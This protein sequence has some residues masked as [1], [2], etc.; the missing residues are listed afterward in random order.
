MN[1][2]SELSK[3]ITILSL[4]FCLFIA[5]IHG[6]TDTLD[7]AG[8][9]PK[10]KLLSLFDSDELIDV[11]LHFDIPAFLRTQPDDKPLEAEMTFY[12][13]GNDSLN[14]KITVKPRGFFRRKNCGFP[15]IML[16]FK[17]AVYANPD[18]FK[19]KKVKLVTHCNNGKFSDD[20]VA[21]EYLLYRMYNV[22]T[23]TS[24]RVRLLRINY[25]DTRGKKKEA[26]Q[27]GFL[28]EPVE[29]LAERTNCIVLTSN[30]L[31][32]KS[33]IPHTMNTVAIFNYMVANW[34]WSVPWQHNIALMRPAT[35]KGPFQVIAVPYDFDLTGVVNATYAVDAQPPEVDIKSV[36]DRLFLG[37][38]RSEDVYR[39]EL[40]Q[41]R[42]KK[43][44]IYGLVRDF[45][46][47]SDKSKKDVLDFLDQFFI[48]LDN[49]RRLDFLIETFRSTCKEIL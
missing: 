11:S 28:I 43:D 3:C 25:N 49:P 45:P 15:P 8:T 46:Y 5:E 44:E 6:Q 19:L 16:N 24:L 22:L 38:C 48:L 36:R 41:F 33:V 10:Y 32:Q 34:D 47:L 12:L 29:Q 31:T 2:R 39:E 23:D 40:L 27:L 1:C 21:R 35:H 42:S 14:R 18:S 7:A 26:T 13:P 4:F 20:Y 30:N 9:S 37:I 17:S